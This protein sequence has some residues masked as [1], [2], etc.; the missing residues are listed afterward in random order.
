[1]K[2]LLN[3]PVIAEQICK[4][5]KYVETIDVETLEFIKNKLFQALDAR[6]DSKE[7]LE[8]YV[9]QDCDPFNR[10]QTEQIEEGDSIWDAVRDIQNDI[11]NEYE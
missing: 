2:T 1:M 6:F 5:D 4:L 3:N 8:N 9:W 11:I 10:P 7:M